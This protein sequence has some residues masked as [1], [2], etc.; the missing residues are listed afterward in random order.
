MQGEKILIYFDTSE[1]GEEF[2]EYFHETI[3]HKHSGGPEITKKRNLPFPFVVYL[4]V[5]QSD[6]F[7][8]FF[9][10][11]LT[12]WIAKQQKKNGTNILCMHAGMCAKSI[13]K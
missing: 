4:H 12:R 5:V 2:L 11:T 9:F 8:M 3:S 1:V 10:S 6:V 13:N 7:K